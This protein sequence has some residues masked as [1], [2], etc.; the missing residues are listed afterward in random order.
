MAAKIVDY[1]PTSAESVW[2]EDA[3]TL[4]ALPKG[5][6]IQIE[7]DKGA[8]TAFQRAARDAGVTARCVKTEELD[9][10]Q[11]AYTFVATALRTREAKPKDADA[12]AAVAD[13]E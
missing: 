6:A 7:G 3:K 2:A 13:T 4:A 1:T 12:V 10:E 8:R 11:F 9:G 5:K